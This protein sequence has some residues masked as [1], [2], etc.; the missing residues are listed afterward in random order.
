MRTPR[1]D[2]GTEVAAMS[3]QESEPI[4]AAMERASIPTDLLRTFVAICELGSFTKAA[5]LFGLTQPAVSSHMRRLESIIGADLLQKSLLGVTLTDFGA[6]V[7][8][9][10]RRMLAINDQIVSGVGLQPNLQVLRIGIP[11]VYAP[12]KLAGILRQCGRAA[13][14]SRVQVRCDHS[15]ALLR[16]V[17]AGHL[18]LVFALGSEEEMQ[19][20]LAAWPEPVVWVRAADLVLAAGAAIPLVSS[21]NLL[22]PDR[23]A[24]AVLEAAHRRY[25]V[26]FTAFDTMARRA[27][28]AAGLGY[29]PTP[30][31]AAM[32]M[33]PL[34]IEEPGVLP[35]L[36]S[37]MKGIIARDDLDTRALAPVIAAFET[38]VTAEQDNS[39]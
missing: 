39:H 21:P 25:E 17:R 10:A 12:N 36:P 24:M 29:C 22:P 19:G 4:A 6:E 30:R 18:D 8:R 38:V 28:A 31:S 7:L 23:I 37:I 2:S 5:H 20:S 14:P 26:V 3:H 15:S 1:S 33:A 34:V 35:E 32:T 9:Q 16:G 13:E 11:N 27:A